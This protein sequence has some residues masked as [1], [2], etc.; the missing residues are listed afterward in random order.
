MT[1]QNSGLVLQGGDAPGVGP[2][3]GGCTEIYSQK[4]AGKDAGL[5]DPR[6]SRCILLDPGD[7]LSGGQFEE[8][9]SVFRDFQNSEE[10]RNLERPA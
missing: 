3:A 5:P 1:L 8:S 7:C 6:G 10:Q 2:Q 4:G 9:Y